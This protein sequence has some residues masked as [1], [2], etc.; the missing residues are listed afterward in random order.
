MQRFSYS[1]ILNNL[2]ALHVFLQRTC[3]A[4]LLHQT[5]LTSLFSVVF[6]NETENKRRWSSWRKGS[7]ENYL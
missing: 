6:L 7:W 1:F 2:S 5:P 3:W 4:V